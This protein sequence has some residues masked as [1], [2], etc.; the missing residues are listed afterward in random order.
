MQSGEEEE[1]IATT[2]TTTDLVAQTAIDGMVV[3]NGSSSV[4]VASATH[5]QADEETE[6]TEATESDEHLP[7]VQVELDKLNYANESI[8]SLELELEESKREYLTTMQESEEQLAVLEKR[9]G[10]CVEKSRPYYEARIELSEAKDKYL[11]V[12]SSM[13]I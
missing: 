9:L 11:K 7:R 4:D 2:T 8:N 3:E 10:V 1:E 12:K 13:I 5:Q 6:S